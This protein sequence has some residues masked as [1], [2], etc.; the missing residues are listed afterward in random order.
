MKRNY[1][2]R[3][4]SIGGLYCYHYDKNII[5]DLKNKECDKCEI[6]ND[7]NY[8][9]WQISHPKNCIDCMVEED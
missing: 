1:D 8:C 2:C 3:Y 4:S 6:N 7:C 9:S 5:D